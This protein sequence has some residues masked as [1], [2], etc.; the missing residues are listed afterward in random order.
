RLERLAASTDQQAAERAEAALA[1]Q[2]EREEASRDFSVDPEGGF[3]TVK[4][5]YATDRKRTGSKDPNR[6]YG[7][8][9]GGLELGTATVSIP[10]RHMPGQIEKPSIWTLTFREDPEKHVVL[11]S[12]VPADADTV[13]AEM[14][15]QLAETGS[16]EAF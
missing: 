6:F 2:A 10:P 15:G 5:Y 3:T 8:E 12:V 9:R 16:D 7:G 14:R 11:S 13:F 1:A 4:I